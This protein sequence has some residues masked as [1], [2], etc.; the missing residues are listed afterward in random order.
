[1]C[2]ASSGTTHHVPTPACENF[3]YGFKAARRAARAADSA[4]RPSLP[5][6]LPLRPGQRRSAGAKGRVPSGPLKPGSHRGRGG[7]DKGTLAAALIGLMRAGQKPA[8]SARQAYGPPP[9]VK[10]A[11]PFAYPCRFP[12]QPTQCRLAYF[13]QAAVLTFALVRMGLASRMVAR[14][15]V[16]GAV[17]PG[18]L[19]R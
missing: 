5:L 6:A 8:R 9:L 4:P 10:S 17:S 3:L 18:L 2:K 13:D 16:P 7:F 14:A 11:A 15:V 12:P 1:M 19:T